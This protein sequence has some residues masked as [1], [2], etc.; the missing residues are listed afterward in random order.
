MLQ[1]KEIDQPNGY[2]D[3][4]CVY[5]AYKEIHYR[6]KDT[7]RL[8]VRGWK[9]IL[10]AMEIIEKQEKQYKNKIDFS[11]KIDFLRQGKTLHID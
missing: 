5:A 7:Y 9:K 4:T 10:H 3:K 2:R 1:L 6:S 11:N 8:K